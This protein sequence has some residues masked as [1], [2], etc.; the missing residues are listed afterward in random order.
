MEQESEKSK[1][2]V[3]MQYCA[4]SIQNLPIITLRTAG[5]RT[6]VRR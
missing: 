5:A 6:M 3:T 1:G 4:A 2:G